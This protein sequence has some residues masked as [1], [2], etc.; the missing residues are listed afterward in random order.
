MMNVFLAVLARPI[1]PLKLLKRAKANMKS[2]T[3]VSTAVLALTL[4]P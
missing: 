1:A 2:T 3:L 4:A